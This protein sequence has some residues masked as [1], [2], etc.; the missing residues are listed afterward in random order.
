MF[1]KLLTPVLARTWPCALEEVKHSVQKERR[2]CDTLEPVIQSHRL[3][4]NQSLIQKDYD[5][6]GGYPVDGAFRYQLFFQL[7]RITVTRVPSPTTTAWT[8]SQWPSD[9][10][11]TQWLRT[12]RRECRQ[13][14]RRQ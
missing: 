11:L 3:I 10:S 4:V 6:T 14:V 13:P 7:T 9:S 2:I 12:L 5:S 1:L 8:A